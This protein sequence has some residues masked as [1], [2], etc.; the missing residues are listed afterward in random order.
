MARSFE[1][2]EVKRLQRVLAAA[3]KQWKNNNREVQ[4]LDQASPKNTCIPSH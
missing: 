4:F 3:E 1:V 2:A